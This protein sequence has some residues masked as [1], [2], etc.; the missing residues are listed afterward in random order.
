MAANPAGIQ[1]ALQ[2][3]GFSIDASI[4]ITEDQ[5]LDSLEELAYMTD[6]KVENLCKVLRRPG[7]T[8]PNPAG[9]NPLPHPGHP[10]SQRA[11]DNLQLACYFVRFRQRT[12]RIALAD[13]ITVEN[14]RAL[15][16]LK[17]W[18]KDHTDVEKPEINPKDWPKTIESI[19]EYLRGCL[20]VTKIPLAYVV[21]ETT[22]IPVA[23]PVGGYS[24]RQ[25]ELIARSPIV[26][27]AGNFLPTYLSDRTKVWELLS[28]ITREK[29]CWTYVRPAQKTRDGRMAFERL[30]G[31]YLGQNNVDNMSSKAEHTLTTTSYTGEKRN[32]NF[33]KYVRTHVDQHSILEGLVPFGYAGIDERSKVRHLL[34]GIKTSTLDNVKTR[35]LSDANLRSNF[36]ACVN[37]YQDFIKQSSAGQVRDVNIAAV[38]ITP[39]TATNAETVSFD[40]QPDMSVEDRYYKKKEYNNLSQAKKLGL[41]LLRE[42]RGHKSKKRKRGGDDDRKEKGKKRSPGRTIKAVATAN[43]YA[44]ESEAEDDETDNESEPEPDKR[45]RFKPHPSENRKNPALRRK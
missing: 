41:K 24:S 5:G 28:D 27:A 20:G 10:V 15:R 16:E 39:K 40:V 37:L 29:E 1:A 14:V 13:M 19:E 12:S 34:N 43:D 44:S 8:I 3:L 25:D 33:E 22:A 23:D 9:G 42:K 17:A 31:H 36:D 2:R 30:K 45:V 11:E 21:R 6:D 4:S 32:W 38:T 7:G 35:I 18:E 26:D